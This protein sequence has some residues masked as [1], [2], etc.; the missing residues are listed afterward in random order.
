MEE[1]EEAEEAFDDLKKDNEEEKLDDNDIEALMDE[2]MEEWDMAEKEN[3]SDKNEEEQSE[4][5]STEDE[6]KTDK[7]SNSEEISSLLDLTD[8]SH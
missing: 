8:S 5:Q 1:L 2:L 4:E 3:F 6:E 7:D